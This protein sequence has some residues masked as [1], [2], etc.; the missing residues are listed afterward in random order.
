MTSRHFK[1]G[2]VLSIDYNH[3]VPDRRHQFARMHRASLQKALLKNLPPSILH[4]GKKVSTVRTNDDGAT[5]DFEDGTSVTADLVI[6]AD[7][8]KSV[9]V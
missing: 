3:N 1:T 6:G 5:V 7:G 9:S 2:D 4:T 8:I